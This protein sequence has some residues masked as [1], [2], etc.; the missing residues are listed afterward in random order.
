MENKYIY[1]KV[2]FIYS[3]LFIYVSLI[4]FYYL[5]YL[6]I[7]K[8]SLPIFKYLHLL[9][10]FFLFKFS[11]AKIK[12]I[13]FKSRLNILILVYLVL[14]FL[15]G[16]FTNYYLI[17]LS[18]AFYYALTGI[19]LYFLLA[20]L[21]WTEKRI[22]NF[23]ILFVCIGFL[24]SIYGLFTFILQKNIIFSHLLPNKSVLISPEVFL[25]YGRIS[26][27]FTN[28]HLLAIFL[29]AIFPLAAY[30]W[31]KQKRL[32]GFLLYAVVNLIIA[33]AMIL[34][35]SLESDICLFVVCVF[36]LFSREYGNISFPYRKIT[37]IIFIFILFVS[38]CVL[39]VAGFYLYFKVN[40]ISYGESVFLGRIK[41]SMLANPH[42]FSFRWES[43]ILAFKNWFI[44]SG[45][46]LGIGK[47]EN[48]T[49]IIGRLTLDNF[50]CTSLLEYGFWATAVMLAVFAS[51]VF[52]IFKNKNKHKLVLIMGVSICSFFVGMFFCEPLHHPTLRIF[53]WSLAGMLTGFI[54]AITRT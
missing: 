27:V 15:S 28:P 51:F 5:P 21:S 33:G 50:Y 19:T 41:L 52:N 4:P 37:R 46:G 6:N 31:L 34:T 47:I 54:N 14:T 48:G 43:V 49:N 25:E 45:F 30:L 39:S 38:I 32:F 36:Y 16:L 23:L 42:G 12:Q 17:S 26:S 18:K 1:S 13:D 7:G 11:L 3:L 10:I 53:F 24:V 29:S 20:A 22:E 40:N 44:N 8:I 2:F 9:F 35:F